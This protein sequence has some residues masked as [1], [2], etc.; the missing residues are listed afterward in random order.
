ME[1]N[2]INAPAAGQEE[3]D[4]IDI[5]AMLR[6]LWE[7]TKVELK[8]TETV[9]HIAANYRPNVWIRFAKE[10]FVKTPDGKKYVITGGEK[11]NEQ[12]SDLQLDS[13]FWMPKSGKA[14]LALHFKP[15]PLD[16]KE[17]DFSEGDVDGAF[18][19]WNIC[20]GKTKQKLVLPDDWKS[21]KYAKD[22]TLP[23]AKINKGVATINVRM[24]GYKPGMKL[25]FYVG[26]FTPLG[27]TESFSKFFPFADDGTLKVEIPL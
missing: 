1:E 19:F 20:D 27:S 25:E 17:M 11:T 5:M 18:R 16:T 24:L 23:V 4:G 22:E 13:L 10:S 21:V 3:E 7:I 6:S 12:E 8:Q 26:G 9:L 15:V 14:N 2:R